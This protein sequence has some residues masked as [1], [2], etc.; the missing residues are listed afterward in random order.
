F[1]EQC[2][3]WSRPE[4]RLMV[5]GHRSHVETVLLHPSLRNTVHA[6]YLV[7]HNLVLHTPTI[8]LRERNSDKVGERVMVYRRCLYC[9]NGEADVQLVYLWNLASGLPR[10]VNLFYGNYVP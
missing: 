2:G 4:V 1:L 9:N 7:L 8:K 3:L 6:I 10:D 5:V